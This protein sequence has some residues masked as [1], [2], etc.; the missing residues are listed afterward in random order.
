M[1]ERV[2]VR[3]TKKGRV[4]PGSMIVTQGTYPK[5][6]TYKEVMPDLCCS[7]YTA[8]YAAPTNFPWDSGYVGISFGCVTLDPDASWMWLY[9]PGSP[10]N[11][12]EL[13]DILNNEA[14]FLGSFELDGT[15][16]VFNVAPEVAQK[17]CFND[18]FDFL[19]FSV[20]ED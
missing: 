7:N 3:Y 5:D 4:V 10:T 16:I 9:V 18:P 17:M 20:F 2:F 13:L 8:R 11:I 6:G 19:G 12:Q 1:K 15:D 14:S